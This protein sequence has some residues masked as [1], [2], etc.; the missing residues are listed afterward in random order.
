VAASAGVQVRGFSRMTDKEVAERTGLDL[1]VASL[2]RR[3][4]FSEPF[5]CVGPEPALATLD[6]AAR[7]IGAR[8]TR[9]G[10]FF[11]LT[12]AIDKGAAVALVRRACPPGTRTLGLG[13]AANDLS[14]LRAVDDAAIV[15]QPG[16]GLHP[17]LV[18]ALPGARH[19]VHPGPAGWNAVVMAWLQHTPGDA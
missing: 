12:G 17:E 8:V 10:R 2:A 11:H 3:R 13:D 5:I 4:Q 7:E 18:L 19:A 16:R 15:P 6:A 1:D 9:G 14:L